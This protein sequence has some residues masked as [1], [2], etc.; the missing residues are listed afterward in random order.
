MSKDQIYCGTM[1]RKMVESATDN[2]AHW[3]AE[4]R[5]LYVNPAH[6][7]TLCVSA[8]TVVGTVLPDSHVAVKAALE[9]VV[10][11][12]KAVELVCQSVAVGSVTEFHDVCLT[13]E[14]DDTGKL[15]GVLGIGRNMTATYLAQQEQAILQEHI[16]AVASSVPGFLFT[17]RAE[18]DGRT[19]FPWASAGVGGMFGLSPEDIRDDAAVLRARYHPEDLAHIRGLMLESESSLNPFRAEVRINHPDHGQRWIEIRSTPK[20]TADGATEWHG[21]MLDIDERKRHQLR[22]AAYTSELQYVAHHDPLTGLSNRA[23]LTGHME[24][25]LDGVGPVTPIFLLYLDLDGFKFVNDTHGH[26]TGDKILKDVAC[27][28]AGVLGP[29]DMAARIGGDEFVILLVGRA[30]RADCEATAQRLLDALAVPYRNHSKFFEISASI[31]IARFPDD[32]GDLDGLMR[33]ADQAMYSAKRLGRNTFLFHSQPETRPCAPSQLLADL[34]VAVK[35]NEITVHYQP[36][37]DLE[38]GKVVKAE[39]LA[40]W[41]HQD[42]GQIS[43]D[44]F[45]PLAEQADLIHELGDNIFMAAARTSLAWNSLTGGGKRIGVNRSPLQFHSGYSMRPLLDYL[46]ENSFSC[47]TLG[48]EITEGIFL[49]NQPDILQQLVE[50]RSAGIT[51]SLDDFGTGYSSLSYL[52]K[53]PVDYLKIDKSFVADIGDDPNDLAIVGA[54]VAMAKQLGIKLI[55]EGVETRRQAEILRGMGCDMAQ[56]YFFAKPMPEDEF[57]RFVETAS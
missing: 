32:A 19:Y 36:I 13:P 30:R 56:G 16:T 40:R 21:L 4:G 3:D 57:L 22:A 41:R 51:V 50:L 29:E 33:L 48:L 54:I 44:V 9:Q 37:I 25:I 23:F 17:I 53:F 27:R 10:A 45:I 35:R 15:V 39:A 55:A 34:K 31:G 7:R 28:I 43:P 20:R 42:K 2:I 6:E 24:Q 47:A 38:N 1:F 14:F 5:Y 49:N 46:R 12:G 26:E 52:R 11:T 18:S 8:D